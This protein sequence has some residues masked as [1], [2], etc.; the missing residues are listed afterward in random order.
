MRGAEYR[1]VKASGGTVWVRE[2]IRV[3]SG[4]LAGVMTSIERRQA[5]GGSTAAFGAYRR[6]PRHGQQAGARFE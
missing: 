1:A 2:T 5:V 3:A 6:A 4:S